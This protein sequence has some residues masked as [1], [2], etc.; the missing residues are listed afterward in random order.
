MVENGSIEK[1]FY[2]GWYSSVDESFY[3]I[4]DTENVIINGEEKKVI[5]KKCF[6]LIKKSF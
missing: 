6:N 5:L 3:T 1:N 4:N 2:S